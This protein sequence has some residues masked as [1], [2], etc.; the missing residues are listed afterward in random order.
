MIQLTCFGDNGIED[1]IEGALELSVAG[2]DFFET[3]REQVLNE[4]VLVHNSFKLV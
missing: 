3:G 4:G 2:G 1:D